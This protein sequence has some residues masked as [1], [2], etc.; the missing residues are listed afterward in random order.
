[1]LTKV[2][3]YSVKPCI[4][5]TY[6][7]PEILIISSNKKKKQ[8]TYNWMKILLSADIISYKNPFR[9]QNTKIIDKWA[10]VYKLHM[11]NVLFKFTV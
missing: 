7:I 11:Q 10:Y 1:M 3:K 9:K 2:P 6:I 5:F 4:L 8:I